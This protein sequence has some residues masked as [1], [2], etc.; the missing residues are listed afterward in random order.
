MRLP[1]GAMHGLDPRTFSR[2]PEPPIGRTGLVVAPNDQ[3]VFAPVKIVIEPG[4][5]RQAEAK[6]NQ[7]GAERMPEINDFR[8]IDGNV[9]EFRIGREY[10]DRAVVGKDILLRRALKIPQGLGLG[11]KPL[12]G[13]HHV[14]LL[15][16]K[17]FAHG[18][19]PGQVVVHPLENGWVPRHRFDT[20]APGLLVNEVWVAT[21]AEIAVGQDNF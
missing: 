19:G 20:G 13:V 3:V 10:F 4:T 1:H 5:H 15:I 9:N 2:P 18:G 21:S 16:K 8:L 11:A 17:G 14:L 7:R 6:G 12:D